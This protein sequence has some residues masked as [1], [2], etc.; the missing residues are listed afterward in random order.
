MFLKIFQ[1]IKNTPNIWFASTT[2]AIIETLASNTIS[3]AEQLPP[4]T[5][6]ERLADGTAL[7][8]ESP[9]PDEIG[10]EYMVFE[11]VGNKT[12]GA[13]YLPQSEF[14]CFYGNFKG[15]ELSITLIDGYDGQEYNYSLALHSGRLTARE[16][17]MMGT[18]TYQP[19]ETVSDN[20]RQILSSCKAQLAEHW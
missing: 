17:P 8:G 2:I 5:K 12:I 13:F 4:S 10:Q 18:L 14:S 15:S 16:L 19:L 1:P 6:I 7:Y 11:K 3:L 9:L 20:D